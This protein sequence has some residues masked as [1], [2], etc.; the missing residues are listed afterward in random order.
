MQFFSYQ[1]FIFDF[2]GTLVDSNNIK[3]TGFSECA[4][5][6]NNGENIMNKIKATATNKNRFSIFKEFS[7]NIP[8][9]K[10]SEEEIY[11]DLLFE[12]RKYT[13]SNILKLDPI[14]GSISILK[15]L[16]N[17]K[18][19]IYINSATPLESLSFVINQRGLNIFF[20]GIYGLES[21]KIM[22]LKKIQEN[23]NCKKNSMIMIGDGLDDK[24][25]A[26]DFGIKFLPVGELLTNSKP[27]YTNII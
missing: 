21:S 16:K 10:K 12:Y 20:D 25:A 7:K 22:N 24:E 13:V 1:T 11:S 18:K 2:D 4:K 6:Y 19:S 3:E 15:K 17:L 8:K 14:K 5:K 26:H 9:T 23:S 27:D